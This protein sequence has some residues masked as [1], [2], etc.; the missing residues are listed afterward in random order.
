MKVVVV[1]S[2]EDGHIDIRDLKEKA[3]STKTNLLE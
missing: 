2:D 1:K 3:V